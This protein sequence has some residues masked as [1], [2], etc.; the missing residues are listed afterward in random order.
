MND[1]LT[2]SHQAVIEA[3]R[4]TSDA[5]KAA[6]DAVANMRRVESW[7][8]REQRLAEGHSSPSGWPVQ[9]ISRADDGLTIPERRALCV[10]PPEVAKSRL[11]TFISTGLE[12][13]DE[14]GSLIRFETFAALS[15]AVLA[16]GYFFLLAQGGL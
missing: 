5:F 9:R 13:S 7:A 6:L 12:S 16:V 14:S 1:N 15:A 3:V 4:E 10:V 2:E 11:R 8:E